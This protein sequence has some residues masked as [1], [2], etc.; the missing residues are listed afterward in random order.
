MQ[1]LTTEERFLALFRDMRS[2]PLLK[3]PK[4]FPL[5]PPQITLLNWVALSPGVGVLDIAHS[6]N[7]TPPTVSVAA[8]RLSEEGL[9]ES[10]QD[11]EDRRVRRLFL[12][13]QGEELLAQVWDYRA[14]TVKLFLSGLETAEQEQLLVLLERAVNAMKAA[15]E[16]QQG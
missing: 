2:L 9:L 16:D 1:Q 5:S 13:H 14:Q 3:P 10:Q 12:T 6:L 7:V 8:R 11:P 4:D 15:L